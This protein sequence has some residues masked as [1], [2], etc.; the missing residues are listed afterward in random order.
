VSLVA[1]TEPTPGQR[2]RFDGRRTVMV[3]HYAPDATTSD[4]N[5]NND[6]LLIVDV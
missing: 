6:G 4:V 1:E 5:L 2:L 3:T